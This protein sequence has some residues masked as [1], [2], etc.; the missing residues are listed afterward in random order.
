[1]DVSELVERELGDVAPA[2][3]SCA[4]FAA[5]ELASMPLGSAKEQREQEERDRAQ[6]RADADRYGDK[7]LA[8]LRQ[9]IPWYERLN[10]PAVLA[11]ADDFEPKAKN[12]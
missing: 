2:P 3:R 4:M 10:T 11:M 5:D 12:R 7:L 1:M 9:D 6:A 8:A